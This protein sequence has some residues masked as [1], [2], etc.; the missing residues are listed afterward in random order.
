MIGDLAA[1]RGIVDD[2]YNSERRPVSKEEREARK[3]LR[4]VDA[5][6]AMVD[7]EKAQKAFY[8]NRDRLRAM[9]LDSEAKQAEAP[10]KEEVKRPRKRAV[11][12]EQP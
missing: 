4:A 2:E 6:K 8:A 12:S 9:R 3:A 11:K 10:L 5:K 7:H 1:E